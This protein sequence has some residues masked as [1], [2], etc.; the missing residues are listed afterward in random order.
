MQFP[1]S[2]ISGT[3][4]YHYGRK[5]LQRGTKKFQIRDKN[6][7]LTPPPC[8]M[9]FP[10][11]PGPNPQE[12]DAKVCE[13]SKTAQDSPSRASGVSKKKKTSSTHIVPCVE[14]QPRIV[15]ELSCGNR[16]FRWLTGNVGCSGAARCF[17]IVKI[18]YR[19]SKS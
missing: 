11:V 19:R 9:K 5:F 10:V 7:S 13:F 17:S 6:S 4:P 8:S 18:L 14:R 12:G 2:E 15:A 1:K 16:N 3:P